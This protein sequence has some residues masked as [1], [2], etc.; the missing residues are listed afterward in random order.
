[1]KNTSLKEEDVF[2]DVISKDNFSQ[3]QLTKFNPFF[4]QNN[5][6]IN[7][8]NKFFINQKIKKNIDYQTSAPP[9]YEKIFSI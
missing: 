7:I 3:D 1:M 5:V 6:N 2:G 4:S 8:N 9:Y